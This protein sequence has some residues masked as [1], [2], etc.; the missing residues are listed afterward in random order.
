VATTFI[1]PVAH[2]TGGVDTHADL[3]VAAA[4]CSS[5]QRLLATASFTADPRGYVELLG[6]LR[7][8]GVVDRVGIEGTGSYGAGLTRFL[9]A[10]NLEVVEADRPDRRHRARAGKSDTPRRRG[11]RTCGPRGP[12]DHPEVSRR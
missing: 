7:A 6:W 9:T 10:D 12:C 11:G 4:V 2:V 8:H 5:S 1:A 3:H